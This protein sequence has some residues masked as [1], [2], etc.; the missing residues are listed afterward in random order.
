M[1]KIV[2]TGGLG[3]IGT[4]LCGLYAG[5]ARSVAIVVVDNRFIAERV[6]QLRDWGI[7]FIHGD[8]LNQELMQKILKEADIVYHLA[9]ITD[10]AYVQ[11]ESN[12]EKDAQ[13]AT[14]GIEGSQNIIRHT[15]PHCKIIFPS[16]HVVYEGLATVR[17]GVTEEV[18][19]ATVL[20][21]S[22]GKVQTENDL[23]ESGKNYVV[24]RLGSVY[25]YGKDTM[26][27]SIL[28]N[29][30][31]K[32]SS[33]DGTV[34]LFAGGVQ[35]KSVVALSDVARCLKFMA[36][37]EDIKREIFHCTNENVTVKE[38]AEICRQINP[39]LT[40]EKTAN[41]IPNPGYTLS[42]AKLLST[43]FAFKYNLRTSIADMTRNW[44]RREINPDLEYIVKGGKEYVDERGRISNYELPEPINLIGYIESKAG[45]MRANHYHPIQEQKCLL[46]SGQ[47]ISIIKDLKDPGAPT[48]TRVI[49]A[50]DLSVIK[51]NVAHAMV[52]TKDSVFLNLVRGER[53]HENYGITHTLPYRLVDEKMKDILLGVYKMECR[54]CGN[55][56]IKRAVS[57]GNS[58]LANNLV[59]SDTEPTETYPLEMNYCP[60][61]HNCQLSCVVP[62]QK[63]F[64]NYLYVSSTT[65]SFR[66]HFE[67][68]AL[69][70]L[71]DFNLDS[72]SLVVDI[73]S[74]DGIALLPFKERGI[75]VL[76]I[77]PATAI[78]RTAN[79]KGVETLPLY[80]TDDVAAQVYAHYGKADIVTA[81]N[82]FAHTDDV[83]GMTRNAFKVLKT[84]GTFIIEVQYL[85]DTIKDLTF[86]N[87]YHEHVNY[88]CVTSLVNFFDS[89]GYV[90]ADVEHIDTHGGSVRVY[91]QGKYSAVKPSVAEFLKKEK[92]F[93]LLEYTTYQEFACRVKNVRTT[94]NAN[95]KNLKERYGRIVGYG[96]PAKATTSLNYFGTS[97]K[98]I[99]YIIEDNV[100]KHGK[101]IPGV[102]IPIKGK[103][104]I[105]QQ[106]PDAVVVLAW[107]FMKDIVN[108]N[109]D[110]AASGVHFV[111]V[112]DLEK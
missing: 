39:A 24:L 110:M 71:S 108:N 95:L 50:G 45:T 100:L 11:T 21:Y 12:S 80:F 94:F 51:P 64:D 30:F 9:G 93:G 4:E 47:Y 15:P 65:A 27:T 44:S 103:E 55:R 97:S 62:P 35:H 63:M 22:R 78:A 31:S 66:K 34:R 102:R 56:D 111:S 105:Q 19:P 28:P 70:Y 32:I 69:K 37:R 79:A 2:I 92:E 104:N 48:E 5:E 36:E 33:Q 88:W 91:V 6:K 101:Y 99:E 8:I 106:R 112:K 57:L 20:V 87:I 98:Y 72:S 38:I 60:R 43:G 41:E 40:I 86:D 89:L 58:P 67:N 16:T 13:I 53:E 73:G 83:R 1:Q 107:N 46:V 76:G 29:L 109:Q 23:K 74:N 81:S 10:V 68:A 49:N 7:E 26:R 84:S 77:E 82:V 52:F 90:V 54:V 25:G 18:P 3:Y 75:R 14:V 17:L 96:S 42:N 85:L 59:N 61:C